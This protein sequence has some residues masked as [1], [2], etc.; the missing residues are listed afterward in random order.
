ML[1]HQFNWQTHH[2]IMSE[3]IELLESNSLIPSKLSIQPDGWTEA[4]F[5]TR[6][7]LD[8][9]RVWLRLQKR[10]IIEIERPILEMDTEKGALLRIKFRVTHENPAYST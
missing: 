2:K 10:G 3:V 4:V 6:S 5:L 1:A 9:R 7:S 8:V